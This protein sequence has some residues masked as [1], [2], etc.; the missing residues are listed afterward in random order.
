MSDVVSDLMN[1]TDE[2]VN[3]DLETERKELEK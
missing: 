2:A 3:R 1:T